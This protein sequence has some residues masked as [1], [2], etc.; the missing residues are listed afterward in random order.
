MIIKGR[1]Y[2]DLI[3]GQED[4]IKNQK[5]G[6]LVIQTNL[7]Q[8]ALIS[9]IIYFS[10]ITDKEFKEHIERAGLGTL[11]NFFAIC[12]DEPSSSVIKELRE[13]K[14]YRD[15]LAHKMFTEKKLSEDECELALSLG[16]KIG[17]LLKIES[18][19]KQDKVINISHRKD[20]TKK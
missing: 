10:R 13:Y 20:Y 12:L 19:I 8:T 2:E 17:E 7:I 16:N 14:K 15:R 6:E 3:K 4:I 11:I 1:T 5:Y 9:F 18:S